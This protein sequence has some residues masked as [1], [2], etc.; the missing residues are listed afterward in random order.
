MNLSNKRFYKLD[1]LVILARILFFAWTLFLLKNEHLGSFLTIDAVLFIVLYLQV[2][3]LLLAFRYR[4]YIIADVLITGGFSIYAAID[5]GF[6]FM[7]FPAAFTMGYFHRNTK[8]WVVPMLAI[9]TPPV[10]A[11]FSPDASCI[12]VWHFV[13]SGMFLLHGIRSAQARRC[14]THGQAQ[15]CR[16]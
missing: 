14:Y 5:L 13:F 8:N 12:G 1:G 3:I 7:F 2:P 6:Y 15:T 11:C 10:A 16:H 9:A 4:A